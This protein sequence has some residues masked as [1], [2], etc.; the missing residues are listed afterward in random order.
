MFIKV[1]CISS[2]DEITR[3]LDLGASALGFVSAMPSGPGPIPEEQIARLVPLVPP[4]V[5]TFLLTSLTDPEAIAAQHERCGTRT[6]QLV[7]HL[8]TEAL[9]A[10]RTLV[11]FARLVQVIHVTGAGSIDEAEEAAPLIDAILLDSGNP[12]AARKELGG[13]GRTHNWSVSAAIR[14]RVAPVPVLLAGGLRG[15]NVGEAVRQVQPFGV[16]VCSG[17]RTDGILDPD[18]LGVFV[19]AA[20]A[21]S[22][23]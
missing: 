13:T 4:S 5:D 14:V 7:D 12:K 10:L 19:R 16:D 6:I 1:C 20:R 2:E 18:K 11:P 15:H 3:A 23:A 21:P 8:G 9:R 22:S 17:V